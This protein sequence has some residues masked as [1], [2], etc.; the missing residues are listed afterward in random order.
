MI[1]AQSKA[2][3]KVNARIAERETDY[4]CC[5][6]KERVILK[7]GRI[8]IPH[9]SHGYNS[10]CSVH[11]E[12]ETQEHL[13]GK[14]DLYDWLKNLGYHPELEVYIAEIN[15]RADI[16]FTCKEQQYA[17]EYQCSPISEKDIII[18]TQGY[19]SV[20][21][22]PVWIAGCKLK[23]K[24]SLS[25]LN[26][27]FIMEND[28]FG[29][30]HLYYDTETEELEVTCMSEIAREHKGRRRHVLNKNDT[31][32]TR[33]DK[34]QP[35]RFRPCDKRN[36]QQQSR[37]LHK[38]RHY[39]V[40]QYRS[41]FELM[42]ENNLTIDQLPGVVYSEIAEEW[43]INTYHVE[44]KLRLIL[45][46]KKYSISRTILTL[47]E[48]ERQF[49]FLVTQNKISCH[50]LPNLTDNSSNVLHAFLLIL[51]FESYLIKTGEKTWE[52]NRNKYNW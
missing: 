32:L 11:S 7:R 33:L 1:I 39:N 17:I 48:V 14:S 49:L 3:I 38:M 35:N 40:R 41:L 23:I 42:Y 15:Q 9:F 8:K 19:Q 36:K 34:R 44:W 10:N 52:I 13:K 27:L 2:G 29:L 21:I 46:L 50:F 24:N 25:V 18:R 45:W 47:N 12:G 4:Y 26:R 6:C 22:K 30:L 43:T 51:E 5:L 20:G 31:S 28:A 37:H 16:F